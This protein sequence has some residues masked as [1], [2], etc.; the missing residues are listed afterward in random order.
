V[1]NGDTPKDSIVDM[2]LKLKENKIN[3][4]LIEGGS[5]TISSFL[6]ANVIDWVQLHIAPKIFGS[7]NSG[8]KLREIKSV[9]ESYS[10]SSLMYTQI[11]DGMMITGRPN[12]I[13]SSKANKGIGE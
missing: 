6:E 1:Y 7:G 3:S 4:L 12:Y 2:L 9:D 11:G 5:T 13:D 10:F 8:I